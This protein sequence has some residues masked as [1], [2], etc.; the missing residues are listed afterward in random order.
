MMADPPL[1]SQAFRAIL[2]GTRFPIAPPGPE[3]QPVPG[4]KVT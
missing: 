2:R 4:A 3:N 1:I